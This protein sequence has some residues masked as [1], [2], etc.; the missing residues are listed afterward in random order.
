MYSYISDNWLPSTQQPYNFTRLG[1]C[2]AD[3]MPISVMNSWFPC[4]DFAESCLTATTVPSGKKP[5]Y[6]GPKP[7]SPSLYAGSKFLV[8]ALICLNVNSAICR[9]RPLNSLSADIFPPRQ[10]FLHKKN[11]TP[12][13]S[14]NAPPPISSTRVTFF[15]FPIT[16]GGLKSASSEDYGS[17]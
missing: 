17:I 8:A 2:D 7:P 1:C 15:F 6:T 16:L 12:R 5:L 13:Q 4:L 3:I 14:N 10:P 9:S 11:R